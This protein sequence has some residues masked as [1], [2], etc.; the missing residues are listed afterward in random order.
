MTFFT[1]RYH[2][3]GTPPGPL[4]DTRTAD[5]SPLRIRLIDYC[6]DAIP[7]VTISKLPSVRPTCRV[8]A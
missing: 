1:K 3:P 6:R 8:S 2:P 7:C 5:T 4:T